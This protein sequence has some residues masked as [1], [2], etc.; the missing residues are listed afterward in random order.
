LAAGARPRLAGA[1]QVRPPQIGYSVSH[2]DGAP[3]TI[4]CFLDV[5]A[6]IGVLSCNHVL[7][8]SNAANTDDLVY[9][10]GRGDAGTMTVNEH[11]IGRL[12]PYVEL[13][14][15]GRNVFDAAYALLS[16]KIDAPTNEIPY[17]FGAPDEGRHLKDPIDTLALPVGARLAKVGRTTGY[18]CVPA[19]GVAVGLNDVSINFPGLGNLRFDEMIEIPWPSLRKPFSAGG[20]S[21]SLCYVEKRMHALAIVVAGGMVVRNGVKI[22]VSYACPL[23]AILTEY[24][25]DLLGT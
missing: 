5:K 16:D 15:S 14:K 24:K 18:T 7:A 2:Q 13:Q 23:A 4:A 1:K 22:G 3:G 17:G 8:R 21:G 19:E 9:Q 10:P 12:A 20:D 6:G 25:A 11:R